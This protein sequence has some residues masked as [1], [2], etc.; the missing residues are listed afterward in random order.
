[1]KECSIGIIEF[2]VL[3]SSVDAMKIDIYTFG[4]GIKII[5]LKRY[6]FD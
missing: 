2:H 6:K 1:M 3:N 5:A 4:I